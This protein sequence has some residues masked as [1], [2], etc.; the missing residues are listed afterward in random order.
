[1]TSTIYV[2]VQ[3]HCL[4]LMLLCPLV[5]AP[6][7]WYP[8]LWHLHVTI[9]NDLLQTVIITSNHFISTLEEAA[10][11]IWGGYYDEEQ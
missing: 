4:L 11:G 1:M 8:L 3:H 9:R 2:T 7:I 10:G 6:L 5:M